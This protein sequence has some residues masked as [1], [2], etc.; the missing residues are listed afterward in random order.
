MEKVLGIIVDNKLNFSMQC[1]YAASK[2]NQ[3]L[4][5]IRKD[6][7]SRDESMIFHLYKTLVVT[8]S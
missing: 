6:M 5:Y 4:Y 2:A 7:A 1:Q 8:A 3:I